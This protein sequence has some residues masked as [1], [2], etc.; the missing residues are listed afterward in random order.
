[1][2]LK[3][4][5]LLFILLFV[6]LSFAWDNTAGGDH[7]GADWTPA[8]AEVICGEHTNVG[9]FAV[10]SGTTVYTCSGTPLNITATSALIE[11]TLSAAGRGFG[12]GAGPGG[13]GST[14]GCYGYGASYGG[15][16]GNGPAVY[17]SLTEPV[18]MGSGGGC[19][20]GGA[21][22][23]AVKL[24]VSGV[25][26]VDGTI[27]AAGA[28]GGLCAHGGGSGGS[29]YLVAG[30]FAGSGTITANGGNRHTC[31]AGSY[32][33]GGGGRIAVYYT[34]NS[35]WAGAITVNGGTL[36]TAGQPGT[37]YLNQ[38]LAQ[39]GQP[40]SSNS[41]CESGYCNSDYDAGSFCSETDQCVHDGA[42]YSHLDPAPD[43]FDSGT[44]RYCDSGT[45]ATQ[46]CGIYSCIAGDCV[47]QTCNVIS[48]CASERVCIAGYCEPLNSTNY[49]Q[50]CT[51]GN[52]PYD[53][54]GLSWTAVG[55]TKPQLATAVAGIASGTIPNIFSGTFSL[56][57]TINGVTYYDKPI[58]LSGNEI[59]N[60][61]INSRI[62]DSS[63][64]AYTGIVELQIS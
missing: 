27:S 57:A 60:I 20:S 30:T 4:I 63:G 49:G 3:P 7:G 19:S 37:L 62:T 45:W 2:E 31:A 23:G 28:N 5:Y 52:T 35:S 21:G 14:G 41:T 18:D 46:S 10:A 36:S 13:A 17:G 48:D 47:V 51:V 26:T 22:G 42:V 59:T 8:N 64:R 61:T 58:T 25:L 43:C 1:M 29:I 11:G 16:G 39:N 44:K 34:D 9:A 54:T 53:L 38:T 40:C 6:P 50:P 33:S 15:K 32:G 12:A 24:N 55:C 56:T